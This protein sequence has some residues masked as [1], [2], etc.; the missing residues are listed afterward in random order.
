MNRHDQKGFTL[1]EMMVVLIIVGLIATMMVV[2][3]NTHKIEEKM[4]TQMIRL[5]ALVTLAQEEAILQGQVM[6]LAI[7]E[8]TY[9]F[10]VR[11]VEDGS[12]SA[13]VDEK[14]FRERAVEEG[15][16]FVL[17]FEDIKSVKRNE[18]FKLAL[19]S[20]D[21]DEK[22]EAKD[23]D[24]EDK[25][26][27]VYIDPSGEMYPFELILQ[28]EDETVAFKLVVGEDGMLKIIYPEDLS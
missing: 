11:N 8:N 7:S 24:E 4:E 22:D 26:Q 28:N 9:R 25:Y 23:D 20:E 6:A 5:Q 27:R 15:T 2:S 1:I 21:D 18:G 17:I 16:S 14:I 10:D 3:L 13:V 12:W 19:S